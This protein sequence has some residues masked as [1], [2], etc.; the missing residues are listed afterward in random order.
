MNVAIDID[1]VF[2]CCSAGAP[3]AASLAAVGFKEGRPNTHP[4][5]GTACRRF[6]FRNAYLELLWVSDPKEAQT[7]I[8]QP[9]RLWER[10]L[11]RGRSACP[12]GIVLRPA[13][14]TN[15]QP[16]FPTWAYRP[17]YL[18]APLA[19]EIARDTPLS[20]PEFFYL[21]F[22]RDRALA[23][24]ERARH[25]VPASELTGIKVWT[26]VA[27]PRS[28]AAAA[29]EAAGLVAFRQGEYLMELT[30]D[31]AIHT[32]SADLRP[33]LPLILRW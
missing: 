9:T 29:V 20:E 2:V 22:Q 24:Q 30:F 18:P 7:E 1:H 19:I 21:G 16:P 4:G 31:R 10:W 11:N 15:P 33:D 8:V 23:G 25:D 12:F 14:A 28:S 27:I 3:E 13:D 5:Q 17:A 32:A 26:P 6:F